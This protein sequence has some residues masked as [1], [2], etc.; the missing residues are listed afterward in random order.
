MKQPVFIGLDYFEHQYYNIS[1]NIGYIVRA[2][3]ENVTQNM[4]EMGYPYWKN[5]LEY[6]SLNTTLDIKYPINNISPFLSIG[7]RIDFLIDNTRKFELYKPDYLNKKVY[8]MIIG[9][10]VKYD[11]KRVQVGI[12]GDYYFNFNEI[13]KWPGGDIMSDGGDITDQTYTFNFF[14]GYKL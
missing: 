13:A 3:E 2:E 10:G 8:G 9:C 6:V 14:L 7:P 5:E 4:R 1:T 11:L 12:R